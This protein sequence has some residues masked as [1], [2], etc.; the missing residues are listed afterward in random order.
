MREKGYERGTDLLRA[1]RKSNVD[2]EAFLERLL[3]QETSFFVI[4]LCTKHLRRE[5]CRNYM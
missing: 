4:R 3:T 2:Y 1:V 5:F